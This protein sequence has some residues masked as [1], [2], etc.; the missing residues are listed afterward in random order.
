MTLA[1]LERALESKRRRLKVQQKERASF[2]YILADLIGRSISRIYKSSNTMPEISKVY[3]NIFNEEEE[4]EKIQ[5]KKDE[6]SA[7]RFK[8]F[9][10]SF[11]QRFKKQKE[12]KDN[13][14]VKQDAN[15]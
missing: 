3:P 4:Q 15:E 7:I 11:N 14:E 8:M 1:E 9:A 13:E 2:D 10:N 6:L 12:K 5:A